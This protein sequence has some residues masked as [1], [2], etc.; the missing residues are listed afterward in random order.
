MNIWDINANIEK[1]LELYWKGYD[2]Y[3]ALEIV[4]EGEKVEKEVRR[5]KRN[6]KLKRHA[7]AIAFCKENAEL[8]SEEIIKRLIRDFG[9]ARGSAYNISREAVTGK[10]GGKYIKKSLKAYLDSLEVE[11][12][13]AYERKMLEEELSRPKF[14]F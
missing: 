13:K 5:L 8:G 14:F 9:Y 3:K 1:I 4:K 6:E 12:Q 7:R 11:E 2:F 10:V